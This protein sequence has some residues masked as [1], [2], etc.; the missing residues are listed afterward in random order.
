MSDFK[1]LTE[2]YKGVSARIKAEIDVVTEGMN[3]EDKSLGKA[4]G[5]RT[6]VAENEPTGLKDLNTVLDAH[7]TSVEDKLKEGKIGIGMRVNNSSTNPILLQ[8]LKDNGVEPG[9]IYKNDWS[10]KDT[11]SL[12]KE[13]DSEKSL[14]ILNRLK[15]ADPTLKEKC[16]GL[17]VRDQ[18]MLCGY[19]HPAFMS[20]VAECIVE[21][22][23]QKP[24]SEIF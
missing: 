20:A 4:V 1:N 11:I 15:E 24:N 7:D 6:E 2:L 22:E 21:M 17:S 13:Y 9:F 5:K 10:L 16:S 8:K 19:R 3:I 23:L 18:I 14:E 12:S